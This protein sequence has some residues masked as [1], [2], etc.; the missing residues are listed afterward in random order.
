MSKEIR[1]DRMALET[2]LRVVWDVHPFVNDRSSNHCF[3]HSYALSLIALT[4]DRVDQ[5]QST[6]NFVVEK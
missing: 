3:D 2:S 6:V 1:D 5:R 4:Y